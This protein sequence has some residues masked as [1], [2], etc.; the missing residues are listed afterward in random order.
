MITK[1]IANKTVSIKLMIMLDTFDVGG[2]NSQSH[3]G[4]EL[5]VV[6]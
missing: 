4:A 2:S 1:D 6:F 3:N 5:R